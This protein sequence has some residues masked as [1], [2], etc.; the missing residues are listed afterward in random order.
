M[1][2]D[3]SVIRDKIWY[4]LSD[5]KYGE[6]YL[7]CYIN[8]CKNHRK[9]FKIITLVF[10]GGGVFGWTIWEPFAWIACIIIAALQIFSLV[11]SE[12]IRSDD[13]LTKIGE[14]RALY[15][16]YFCK[17]EKLWVNFEDKKT[18]SATVN[19][20]FF[21]IRKKYWPKI[22][23]MDDYLHINGEIVGLLKRCDSQ[24]KQYQRQ[25]YGKRE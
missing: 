6:V 23:G 24:L 9:Y 8:R 18:D 16:K 14:L 21:K 1:E 20:K 11:Q 2:K 25:L 22:E 12:I 7:A 13:D 5:I 10:S 19:D 17:L 3:R 15:I 4:E